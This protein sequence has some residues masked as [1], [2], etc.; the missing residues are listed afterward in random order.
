MEMDAQWCSDA[1]LVAAV[2]LVRAWR[3]GGL[4]TAHRPWLA[5]R[6]SAHCSDP[7]LVDEVV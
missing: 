1:D 6:L 7:G 4:H 3:V 2:E 5:L